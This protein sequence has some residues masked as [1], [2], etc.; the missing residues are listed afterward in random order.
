[1]SFSL[2]VRDADGR[3][4]A[5]DFATLPPAARAAASNKIGYPAVNCWA[6]IVRPLRGLD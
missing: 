1:M 5:C 3:D 2:Q 4:F 6:I